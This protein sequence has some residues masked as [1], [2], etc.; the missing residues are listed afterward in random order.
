[1]PCWKFRQKSGL[2]KCV[3]QYRAY[4]GEEGSEA[5]LVLD[6]IVFI[7]AHGQYTGSFRRKWCHTDA[8]SEFQVCRSYPPQL[9]LWA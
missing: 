8:F 4:R 3:M 7:G 5:G 9:R 6:C 1:M 2:L